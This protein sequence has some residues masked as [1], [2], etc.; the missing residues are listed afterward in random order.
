MHQHIYIEI[1]H[2]SAPLHP[3]RMK[4]EEPRNRFAIKPR[5]RG[6]G[7][8]LV[9]TRFTGTKLNR[10]S[11]TLCQSLQLEQR[12]GIPFFPVHGCCNMVWFVIS[13]NLAADLEK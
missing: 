12:L 1:K 7:R 8:M 9:G 10:R 3:I 4:L 5:L 11:D 2:C 6:T 13:V